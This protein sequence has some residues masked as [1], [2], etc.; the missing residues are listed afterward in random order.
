MTET[1]IIIN[2]TAHTESYIHNYTE[3]QTK[4]SKPPN[5][6]RMRSVPGYKEQTTYRV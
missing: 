2:L 5:A 4:A 3:A 6:Q 1:Q